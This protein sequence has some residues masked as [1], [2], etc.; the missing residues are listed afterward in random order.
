MTVVT[1]H[2]LLCPGDEEYGAQ[3]LVTQADALAIEAA[4]S[5]LSDAFDSFY[6]RPGVI[7]NTT[8]NFGPVATGAEA[9]FPVS[10]SWALVYNNIT[11]APTTNPPG[12]GGIRVTIP[13]NG[14]Y[15]Y[16]GYMNM[17]AS[18]A[19]TALSRRTIVV[20]A[21]RQTGSI[22]I[23]LSQIEWRT[24]DTST[25]GEFLIASGGSFYATV[26]Q[27]VDIRLF[28][29]HANA[30]SAVNVP[31]GARVWCYFASTGIEIGSA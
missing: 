15:S 21:V 4:L 9:L 13:R 11:P 2:G 26:G 28:E 3:T 24:V 8:A 16:G 31:A 10:S 14:W 7:A 29:S 22:S 17:V 30:A 12:T 27:L 5:G 6:L 18:G 1:P 25:A 19:I 23:Q 20:N